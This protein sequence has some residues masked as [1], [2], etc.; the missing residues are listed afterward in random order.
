MKVV[1]LNRK[2]FL[3]IKKKLNLRQF[4]DNLFQLYLHPLD[5]LV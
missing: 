1:Y 2:N 4:Y 3:G 5:D